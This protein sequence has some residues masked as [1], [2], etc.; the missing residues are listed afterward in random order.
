MT[1]M[2]EKVL[3]K[4]RKIQ[5][6]ADNAGTEGEAQ[7]AAIAFQNLLSKYGLD[8]SQ[9][10]ESER[11]VETVDK[12][13]VDETGNRVYW[14][15]W[16]AMV[17]AQNFR[18]EVYWSGYRGRQ[19]LMFLGMTTDVTCAQA[20]YGSAL[21]TL[22]RLWGKHLVDR[23]KQAE[24]EGWKWGRSDGKEAGAAYIQGFIKGMSEALEENANKMALV[25]VKSET[26]DEA[27]AKLGLTHNSGGSVWGGY[28]STAERA[29]RSDGA[30]HVREGRSGKLTGKQGQ[31]GGGH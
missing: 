20:A 27:V 11:I 21:Q 18:C 5:A 16:L 10:T 8:A 23:A 9:V 2:E 17:I 13:V 29:G 14:R 15:G 7:A 26:V 1:P 12:L 24:E 3:D 22:N 19:K 30:N 25:L 6:L 31:I 28:D 4:L